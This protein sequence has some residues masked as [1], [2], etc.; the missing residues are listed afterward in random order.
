MAHS[1]SRRGIQSVAEEFGRL[2][3]HSEDRRG[4]FTT[5]QAFIVLVRHL[6]VEKIDDVGI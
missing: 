1:E 5:A 4:T 6:C 2:L 3:T